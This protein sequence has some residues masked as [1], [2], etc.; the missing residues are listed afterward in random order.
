MKKERE[1]ANLG[2]RRERNS[3]R[4]VASLAA[5]YGVG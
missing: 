2:S 4:S 1:G 5:D 3:G